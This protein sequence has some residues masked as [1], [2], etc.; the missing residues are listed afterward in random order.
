M[1]VWVFDLASSGKRE[2]RAVDMLMARSGEFAKAMC[3]LTRA[4]GLAD[5]IS[6]ARTL[7]AEL[8]DSE[9][10]PLWGA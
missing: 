6:E 7:W 4:K 10:P 5:L 2:A 3:R 1:G 9:H 8:C